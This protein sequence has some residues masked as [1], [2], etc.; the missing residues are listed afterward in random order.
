[1][2]YKMQMYRDILAFEQGA[3]QFSRLGWE[4]HS[5]RQTPTGALYIVVFF[6]KTVLPTKTPAMV[7]DNRIID[8]I[9]LDVFVAQN[10]SK[11]MTWQPGGCVS[12]SSPDNIVEI[13]RVLVTCDGHDIP[14]RQNEACENPKA[15]KSTEVIPEKSVADLME[16][17]EPRPWDSGPVH[18]NRHGRD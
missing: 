5:W 2:E 7:N 6:N 3:N 18:V 8:V 11:T 1:M 14:H 12:T 9:P 13:K 17:I 15:E 4:L 10:L 16:E